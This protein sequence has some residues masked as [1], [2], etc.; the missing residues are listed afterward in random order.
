VCRGK[1]AWVDL[2]ETPTSIEYH[3]QAKPRCLR[4]PPPALLDPPSYSHG[5]CFHF[6]A[7]ARASP[8]SRALQ[9][10]C[11]NFWRATSRLWKPVR[12]SSPALKSNSISR[13]GDGDLALLR[14]W[15]HDWRLCS[16][17]NFCA[18]KS[19]ALLDVLATTAILGL[20]FSLTSSILLRVPTTSTL[21]LRQHS[22]RPCLAILPPL[23]TPTTSVTDI[24]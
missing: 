24:S 7:R 1:R 15:P 22:L 16:W 14:G 19:V 8:L 18:S 17:F 4:L 12:Y 2:A 21:R 3:C 20:A 11:A 10:S 6:I 13:G 9:S 5:R 23:C